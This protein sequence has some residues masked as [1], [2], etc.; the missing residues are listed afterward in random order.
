MDHYNNLAIKYL[1]F[2][3]K[4]TILTIVGVML[5]AGLLFFIL[6]LYFSFFFQSRDA[7]RESG[8]YEM[9]FFP[10]D[11][12]VT[13]S[14]VNLDY[15]KEAYSGKYYDVN[16]H[17]YTVDAL[18]INLNN[19][20][21]I[22]SCFAKITQTY[23]VRG[24]INER[25]A[26]YYLQGDGG[27]EVYIIL[28]LFLLL[29]FIFAIIGVGIIRNTIQL[30][31]IEQIKDYG[32]LRCIGATGKQ[33][34]SIIYRM[35]AIQ[36]LTGVLLGMVL[37]YTGAVIVGIF[38]HLK[39]R[40]YMIAIAYVLVVFLGDL[41]FVMKENSK[42]VRKI[43]PIAAVN[44]NQSRAS[45]QKITRHKRNIFGLMFGVDGD[46]AYKSLVANKRRF[47]KSVASFALGIAAF[48]GIATMLQGLKNYEQQFYSACG[49]YEVYFYEPITEEVDS[50][51]AK[52]KM[53]SKEALKK[54]AEHPDV[55]KI[56]SIYSASFS[57]KN[58]EEFLTHYDDTF[59]EET[60]GGEVIQE[61]RRTKSEKGMALCSSVNVLGYDKEEMEDTE[62]YLLAGTLDVS[63]DGIILVQNALNYK[64]NNDDEPLDERIYRLTDYELGDE[65]E[66]T[67][68][69]KTKKYTIEGIVET[70]KDNLAQY[71]FVKAIL[72]LE[73]Y[74]DITGFSES[75][76]NGIK[77]QIDIKYVASDLV[78][79]FD[80]IY[81]EA[82]CYCSDVLM[83]LQAIKS[84]KKTMIYV[85]LFVVF[86]LTMSSLNII[87]TTASNLHQRR[88]EFMQLRVI[89]VSV[90]RLRKMIM[91]EG[92]I[93]TILSNAIGGL[94]GF[95]VLVPMMK[96]MY[97][98]TGI[99]LAYPFIAVILGLVVSFIVFCGSIY[100]SLRKMGQGVLQDI[101]EG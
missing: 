96:A 74:F 56:K 15:V 99:R 58:Q 16:E 8:N 92:V 4:R 95:G 12:A 80:N 85:G 39:V 43:S 68:H 98:L 54:I 23:D 81:F 44:D 94:L 75:D 65:L 29:S 77:Y 42:L 67:F 66:L 91:M 88:F 38:L 25:L 21:K 93:T 27:N 5:S 2:Q 7:V 32:I 35:G 22:N 46:Y 19:P 87:N 52:G 72:P 62:K 33:L 90:K 6:T 57:A 73:Y 26:P 11:P 64:K 89:G 20:Y 101:R 24:M 31:T 37:G 60:Y 76:A 59:V 1:Q 69:G 100:I 49:E 17:A 61:V 45:N 3:K 97:V 36:E 34:E 53:P 28:I 48:V 41:Y 78:E 50:D 47:F 40:I 51:M 79:L 86:V 18:Y 9:V 70:E 82:E 30:N 10:E 55:K 71:G 63:K 14:I 83:M 84:T 13:A